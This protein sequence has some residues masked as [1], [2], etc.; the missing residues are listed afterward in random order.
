MVLFRWVCDDNLKIDCEHILF[1][2]YL[3]SGVCCFCPIEKSTEFLKFACDGESE[4]E[5]EVCIIAS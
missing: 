5:S 4:I 3:K 1:L 2:F